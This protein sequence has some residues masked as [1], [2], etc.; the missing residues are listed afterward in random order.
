[1]TKFFI[2]IG[3][4]GLLGGFALS[5]YAHSGNSFETGP[6]VFLG[7]L[8]SILGVSASGV[9]IFFLGRRGH[10]VLGIGI[11]SAAVLV[12]LVL[13]PFVWPYP[14]APGPVPLNEHLRKAG[15]K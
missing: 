7:M 13:I 3:F 14:K 5:A 4:L 6:L 9:L 8:I 15:P 11:L 10:L 12:A 2:C 1:M